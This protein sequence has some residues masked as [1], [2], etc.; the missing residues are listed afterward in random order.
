[1]T[2][3]AVT[4]Q[5][6][7][8]IAN[9]IRAKNG[10]SDTY[11][12]SEMSTAIA[13]IPSGGSSDFV[14]T[15]SKSQ[16]NTW[17]P[18]CTFAELLSAS[19]NGSTIIYKAEAVDG[20]YVDYLPC[21]G[22]KYAG[23]DAFWYSLI[24]YD[25]DDT[26]LKSYDFD[27]NGV[28]ETTNQS[29][30]SAW[31]GNASASD[32]ASGKIF[33]NSSGRQVGTASGGG[34]SSPYVHGTFTTGSSAGTQTVTIPYSGSSSAYPIMAVVVV[35]GG[36]YV[37]GTDWYNTIQRYAVGQWTMTKSVMSTTPTYGSSGTQNQGVTTAIYKSSTSSSTSYTR[38]SAMNT[39]VY[40]SYNASNA[41]LTCVRFNSRTSMSVYVNTS[42][43]GLFPNT[44]Y[45]Y[46]IVYSS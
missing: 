28:L 7:T 41:A 23:E 3:V 24:E 38:T 29:Y 30:Y 32:V 40:S 10:S 15:L 34:G 9:A 39:N 20:E 21:V 8:N 42:S 12:P 14:V 36:A 43:Y 11:T 19:N 27:T 4:E 22:G 26:I 37:S 5:Y 33:Y 18:D 46:F 16:Q 2:K 25:G 45:E 13:N 1:M 17:T 31:D 35:S 6:L 44:E